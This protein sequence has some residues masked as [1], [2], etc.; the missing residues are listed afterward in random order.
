MSITMMHKLD[1]KALVR[2]ISQRLEVMLAMVYCMTDKSCR[3]VISMQRD[4]PDGRG[5]L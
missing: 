4:E 2:V 5:Y 3:D 1:K